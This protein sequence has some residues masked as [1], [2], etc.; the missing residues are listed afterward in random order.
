MEPLQSTVH[1]CALVFE[2]GGYRGSFSAGVANAFLEQGVYFDF[3]CGLS[4]GASNTVNYVSR[5]QWRTHESFLVNETMRGTSGV[6]TLMRGKGYF[7]A[8]AIY[9]D[10]AADGRLPFDY[11]TFMANPARVCIQ[12]FQR[13]TGRTVR[14]TKDDMTS[15]ERLVDLVR[16]SSTLPA[17]MKPLPVD[18]HVYY[19]GGLGQG[20]GIPVNMAEEAGLER[21][22]FVATREPGYRKK[23]PTKAEASYYAH[24]MVDFP[25][26]KNAVLTRWERYNAELGRVERMAAEGRVLIVYPDEMTVSSGTTNPKKLAQA[27]EQGHAVALRELDRILAFAA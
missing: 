20:A 16:A 25:Y 27:Y 21:F 6:G 13:D 19:D 24:T 2:G 14:F 22:V 26:L 5:D 4:A 3:V 23:P 17:V 12:A 9:E 8:Q 11:Q 1:D 10:S 15:V 18:G 7:D